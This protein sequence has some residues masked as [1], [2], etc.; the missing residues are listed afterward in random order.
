MESHHPTLRAPFTLSGSGITRRPFWLDVSG[1]ESAAWLHLP[2]DRRVSPHGVVY[3]PPLGFEYGHGHRMSLH[4][5]DALAR[6]GFAVIRVDYPG[7]GNSHGDAGT[8][9]LTRRWIDCVVGAA[10]AAR[11][12]T[13]EDPVLIGLRAG[14]GI[15]TAAAAE[16]NTHGLVLWAP[17]PNGRHLVR[18]L[19]T[20]HRV[21]HGP[22]QAEAGFIEAGGYQYSEA[23]IAALEQLDL[24]GLDIRTTS[25][26]LIEAQPGHD[27]AP[28]CAHLRK[29]GEVHE[30]AQVD[31]DS[32]L[33]EPQDTRIP[34]ATINEIVDWFN[35]N[36]TGLR[37]N[38]GTTDH[39]RT[40]SRVESGATDEFVLISRDEESPLVGV[41]TT[42][43]G[44]SA[45]SAVILNAGSVHHVGPNR[46][47]VELARDLAHRGVASLR[48][49]LSNLGESRIGEHPSENHPYPDT[50]QSD[51]ATACRW[52]V[53]ER[54]F[55]LTPLVGLCSGAHAVFHATCDLEGAHI[56][57]GVSVNPLTFRYREGLSLDQPSADERMA[58]DTS[59]YK[60]AAR[61]RA[62]WLRLVKGQSDL[63][64]VSGFLY[65]A[66]TE[67]LSLPKRSSEPRAFGGATVEC[68]ARPGTRI[69]TSSS[70]VPIPGLNYWLAR[71]EKASVTF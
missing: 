62:R 15:A 21:A 30:V 6:E 5:A 53:E 2:T 8:P 65:R 55:E 42:P 20:L 19:T 60:R 68:V 63:R 43:N 67:K 66:A 40:R 27:L 26:L 64:N 48:F 47:H 52:L 50:A 16:S 9:D 45:I 18:E 11:T 29:S 10:M 41:L 49:D 22:D 59:Y 38:V 12:L 13:G 28:L 44:G 37:V 24:T 4:L 46:L 56:P 31:F 32:M 51:T 34:W 36:D 57:C 14:A 33:A 7:T 35:N 70:R 25:T 3:C 23:T 54:G 39:L 69:S 61:S 71:G 58:R 17:V 1:L